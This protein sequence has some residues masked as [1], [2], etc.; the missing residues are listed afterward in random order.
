M[1]TYNPIHHKRTE[2]KLKGQVNL[3][4]DLIY[5]DKEA[6]SSVYWALRV[7]K[8]GIIWS[9]LHGL[10]HLILTNSYEVNVIILTLQKKT[11]RLREVN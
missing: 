7:N 11:L 3:L 1:M 8:P 4:L 5:E 2:Q 10:S 9:N 6:D